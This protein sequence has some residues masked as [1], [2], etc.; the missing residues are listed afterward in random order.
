MSITLQ[1]Y[2]KANRSLFAAK[3]D[4]TFLE[5]KPDFWDQ[6]VTVQRADTIYIEAYGRWKEIWDHA[7]NTLVV[8]LKVKKRLAVGL[9]ERGAAKTGVR[10][11]HTYGTPVIPGSSIKGVLRR[12]LPKAGEAQNTLFGTDKEKAFVEWQDAWWIPEPGK[13][14]FRLDVITPHHQDYPEKGPPTDFD[15]P[16]P[17]HFLSFTGSFL[18]VAQAASSEMMQASKQILIEALDRN[19]VGAKRSSGYGRMTP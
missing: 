15:S 5:D 11:H 3:F 12:L 1:S 10:L 17:V 6:F 7:P 13:T 18:F 8:P 9:G 16:V 19:G 14:G 4:T 2:P